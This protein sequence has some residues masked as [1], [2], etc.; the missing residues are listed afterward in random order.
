VF[1]YVK[2]PEKTDSGEFVSVINCLKET[3]L[4]Q[5]KGHLHN[6]FC[7]N[8]VSYL[9]DLTEA[10]SRS[11]DIPHMMK[12]LGDKGYEVDFAGTHWK[13]KLPQYKHCIITGAVS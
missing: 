1:S 8:S 10:I 6:H 2:N 4:Q 9:E 11:R 13:M 12:Y 5:I 3:A 7:F